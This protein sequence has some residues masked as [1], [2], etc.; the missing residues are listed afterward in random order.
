[1][2]DTISVIKVRDILMVTMPPE[3]DDQTISILQDKVLE[4]MERSEARG[5]VLDISMVDS[6]DSYFARTLMETVQMVELMGWRM[7]IA[8]MHPM[9]A[10]TATQ[11]GLLA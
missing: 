1:M 9:V 2:E 4:A 3:P 8:G 10:L 5:L 7:V 6:L 11:L